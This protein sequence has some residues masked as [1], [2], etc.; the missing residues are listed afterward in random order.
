M[1]Y[2][3]VPLQRA[4]LSLNF[5]SNNNRKQMHFCLMLHWESCSL[6]SFFLCFSGQQA[7]EEAPMKIRGSGTGKEIEG[8]L[9]MFAIFQPLF[10]MM[11]SKCFCCRTTLKNGPR[12]GLATQRKKNRV[13]Y[14]NVYCTLGFSLMIARYISREA[15]KKGLPDIRYSP[16][17]SGQKSLLF[18]QRNE[19]ET[20]QEFSHTVLFGCVYWIGEI[21][22]AFFLHQ[23]TIMWH[24][25]RSSSSAFSV[26]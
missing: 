14:N 23:K 4:F 25:Q 15:A 2:A 21:F 19:S 11:F 5:G 12:M 7:S 26:Q 6:P 8:V 10:L 3:A 22:F 9:S 17:H 1:T 24:D 13:K 16:T 20:F 18:R